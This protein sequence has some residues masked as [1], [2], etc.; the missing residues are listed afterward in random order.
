MEIHRVSAFSD[1]GSGGNPAG[2]AI[3]RSMP[4]KERMQR[5][6]ADVGY[7][8]TVFA[9]Q[10]EDAWRVRYFSPET[11]VPFCGHATIALGAV[12]AMQMGNDVFKLQLNDTQITVEGMSSDGQVSGAFQSPKTSIAEPPSELVAE[13][14]ALFSY[15]RDQLDARLPPMLINAG[16]DHMALTLN[17]R[18]AILDMTYDLSAGK[19]LMLREGWITVILAFAETNQL[20]HTRNPFASGGVYE[21]PATGS[22]SAAY[23]GY[24]RD[25]NWP[26]QNSL[27]FI[28]GEDMGCRSRVR[29][30]LSDATGSSVR[31]FGE[32][33]SLP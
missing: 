6:A 7:S 31:V 16:S 28:Q 5:I 12:L 32:A 21:D 10:E 8:E 18:Q 30:S 9:C 26:H 3:V 25:M 15:E 24:L 33:V 20:F 19:A 4:T 11:E 23:A 17:T 1:S 27:E 14:L 29:V 22:A 13:T 2:V